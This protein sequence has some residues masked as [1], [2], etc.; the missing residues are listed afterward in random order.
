MPYDR[1]KRSAKQAIIDAY[2]NEE[3]YI[4]VARLL[5]VK[6]TTAYGI[7][8]RWR[9]TGAVDRPRGGSRQ[10]RKKIDQEMRAAAVQ[11]VEEHAAFTLTQILEELAQRLPGKPRISLTSLSNIL[12]GQFISVK[13]LEDAPIDRNQLHV[14]EERREFALWLTTEGIN[15][16]LLYVD[17]CGFNQSL[18]YF[19]W[20]QSLHQTNKRTGSY[21]AKS[22]EASP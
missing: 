4:E 10:Q 18:I 16:N 1:V 21:W 5:Q 19:L 6:R 7:I 13:K 8:R 17:E 22:R 11:I 20:F 14:K 9:E 15:Q 2:E 3:D 12:D